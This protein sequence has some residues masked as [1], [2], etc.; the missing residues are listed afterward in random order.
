VSNPPSCSVVYA[1]L[2]PHAPILIPTIAGERAPRVQSTIAA[3]REAAR[4]AVASRPDAIILISPHAPRRQEAFGIWDGKRLF[5]TLKAF[6]AHE[7]GVDFP[8]DASLARQIAHYAAQ[9]GV[10]TGPIADLALDHGTVVPLWFIAETGWTGPIVVLA[11]SLAEDSE[12]VEFGEAV[13]EAA[14]RL[15]KRAVFIASGDMSH[16]LTADAPCGFDARG[17]EFD[18]WLISKLRQGAH[19]ELLDFS[20]LLKKGAREDALDSAL[21]ALGATRFDATGSEVLSYEG[22]FGV[23]YGVAILYDVPGIDKPCLSH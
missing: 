20:P 6:G 3:M 19:R 11:L 4:R 21:V 18:Y 12:L 2:M 16:R 14:A 9:R 10:R 1:S 5:G 13:A 17:V 23:G 15:G 7:E 8:N 22:P